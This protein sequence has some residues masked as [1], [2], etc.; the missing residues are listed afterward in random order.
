MFLLPTDEPANDSVAEGTVRLADGSTPSQGRVEVF[1]LGLWGTV[2]SDGWEVL[3][4]RVVCRQLGYTTAVQA[5]VVGGGSGQIWYDDVTCKGYETSIV[6]CESNGLA[7]HNCFHF[8]DAG[9]ECASE[10]EYWPSVNV[11]M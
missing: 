11:C 9:V 7:A 4:A 5:T 2:C 3:D 6:E 10:S 8:L 1:H